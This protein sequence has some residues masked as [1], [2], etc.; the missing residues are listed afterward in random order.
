M[1]EKVIL[2]YLNSNEKIKAPVKMEIPKDCPS[3]IYILE[4][5]GGAMSNHVYHSTFV[6]QSISKDSRYDAS[7]L[8]EAVIHEMVYGLIEC[9]DIVGVTLNSNYDFTDTT[10][11]RYRYQ[12]VFDVVHY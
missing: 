12:A 9:P 11:K 5:T 4:K 7:D 10:T 1:I 3:K 2:D 6:V 8:N